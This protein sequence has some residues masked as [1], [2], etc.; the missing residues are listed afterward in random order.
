VYTDGSRLGGP[1][2]LLARNGW[3]FVVLNEAN[4]MIASASG[5]PPDWIEDIPATEAW[6]LKEAASCALPGCHFFV[7][8]DPCVKAFH[9]GRAISCSDKNP[10]ARVHR[11]MH[12]A[13]DGVPVSSVVW[14]PAR[15]KPGQCGTVVRG[16]GFLLTEIDVAANAEA[17]KLAKQAV[18]H[19]RVPYRIRQE[20][21]AHDDLVTANAMWIARAGVVANQQREDPFRDTQASRAKA[22]E[23]AAAKR[24]SKAQAT[25]APPTQWNPQT[26]KFTKVIARR[27]DQGGH[28]IRRRWPGWWCLTCR[29]R[30]LSWAKLAPQSC[31]GNA[32][33]KWAARAAKVA[34]CKGNSGRK[35]NIVVSEPLFWCT[36]CGSY[37]ET[38]PKLLFQDCRGKHQGR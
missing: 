34:R 18:E 4:E 14:M 37:A 13:L 27:P 5:V 16:D 33:N 17:D 35:H 12:E 2:P 9:Q 1:T 26:C 20:I 28:L 6:A 8:C 25:A 23:A 7:D 31:K 36:T 32:V 21:K 3:A 30:S 10:L 11:L 29:M 22:A 38:A 24:Q 19:H 15:L